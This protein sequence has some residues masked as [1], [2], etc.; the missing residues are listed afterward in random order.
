MLMLRRGG[1]TVVTAI[2]LV[3]G[4]SVA[5]TAAPSAGQ[6]AVEQASTSGHASDGVLEAGAGTPGTVESSTVTGEGVPFQRTVEVRVPRR[7]WYGAGPTGYEYWDYWRV[8]G[9]ARKSRTKDDF[10]A[11]G[12]LSEGWED[13]QDD[14]EGRWY[15]AECASHVPAE[16]RNEY[17]LSHP[18][19][20]VEAGA[21]PPPVEEAVDPQVLA[22]VAF[23][24]MQLPEATIRWNPSLNG[25]GATIVN[26]PT[27][28]WVENAVSQVQVTARVPGVSS[29]VT[30]T[31]G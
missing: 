31:R 30:A 19:V 5:A 10:A 8:G 6:Q 1:W 22:Q 4:A 25:S 14:H 7:C 12:L 18:S 24:H 28:V 17:Y 29:T 15:E 23:E 27:F 3:L 26:L 9:E 21:T 11:Q 20:Y 2:L 16:E 13:H